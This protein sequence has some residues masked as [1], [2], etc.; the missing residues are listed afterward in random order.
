MSF[1]SIVT[2]TTPEI[3]KL[4]DSVFLKR[5]DVTLRDLKVRKVEWANYKTILSEY[6]NTIKS[7]SEEISKIINNIFYDIDRWE[8]TKK[9][10]AERS[11]S[12]DME[13]S[14]DQAISTLEE[15]MKAA[16]LRLDKVFVTQ[17]KITDLVLVIDE[18]ISNI[19]FWGG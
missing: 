16:H 1:D 14:F 18:E 2:A 4:V 3:L 12:K 10:L 9:E 8:L 17:K 11:E 15:I 13:E 7:R 6:Q 5:E 19:E